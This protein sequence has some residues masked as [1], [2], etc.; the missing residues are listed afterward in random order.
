MLLVELPREL[1]HETSPFARIEIL[2]RNLKYR[3][4]SL[5]DQVNHKVKKLKELCSNP[6]LEN[7]K[8]KLSMKTKIR[9]SLQKE[10]PA[11]N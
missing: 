10:E 11:K 8:K 5:D 4:S 7:L 1:D 3:L 2:K 9:G 6:Q